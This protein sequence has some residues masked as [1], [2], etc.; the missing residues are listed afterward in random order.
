MQPDAFRQHISLQWQRSDG[1]AA[2]ATVSVT[3]VAAPPTGIL[4]LA[5][6]DTGGVGLFTEHALSLR[7]GD[8]TRATS[9]LAGRQME[10]REV[11]ARILHEQLTASLSSVDGGTAG[12]R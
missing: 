3:T 8:P 7:T 12:E 11:V 4:A 9:C 10:G 5:K 2:K 1:I 6:E